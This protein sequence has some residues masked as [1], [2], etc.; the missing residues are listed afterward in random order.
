MG[1]LAASKM[2]MTAFEIS[3]PMPSPGKRTT[4]LLEK[5][6]CDLKEEGTFLKIF[7]VLK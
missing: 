5:A 4:L 3:G 1:T 2:S 7:M 6:N